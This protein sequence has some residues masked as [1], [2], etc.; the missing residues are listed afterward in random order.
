MFRKWAG[1]V[2]FFVSNIFHRM[3]SR[4]AGGETG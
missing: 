2:G 1:L 4:G 3:F